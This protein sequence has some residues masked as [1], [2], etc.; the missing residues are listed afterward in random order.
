MSLPQVEIK[1]KEIELEI[2]KLEELSNQGID[3]EASKQAL[4]K[5]KEDLLKETYSS[6]QPSDRVY[7]SRHFLRPNV[8]EYVSHIFDDF[9]EIHG[10]RLYRDDSSIYGGIG[11]LNGQPVTVIGNVKGRNVEENLQCNFGMASPEGYRKAMRL[12]KQA[13]KFNR[14]II[15][16]VDT[17]GAYPGIKA[18]KHGQGEAIASS[19]MEMSTLSVPIITIVIGEGGS[20]GA[21][22]LSVANKIA[23]LENAIYSVLS[24][25]GFAS[26]LWKDSSRVDEASQMM[27]LTASDLYELDVIDHII[28]EPI[29]GAHMQEKAVFNSVKY[30][31]I[32]TLAE[33]KSMKK[34]QLLNSRYAKFR[35]IGKVK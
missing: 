26:I 27:K 3:V 23:M 28:E 9:I 14:P 25:E 10:D 12:M 24:P 33:L 8:K 22:A 1:I 5:A 20:G 7:L 15:T 30:Y 29:G 31:L 2:L 32:D 35:N 6:L 34:E 11:F 19:I 13:E 21:L 18:E 16:F 17:P 4:I